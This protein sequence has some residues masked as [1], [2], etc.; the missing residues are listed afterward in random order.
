[1][2]FII[3]NKWM[4][5]GYGKSLRNYVKGFTIRELL[6]F[7]DLPVFEEATTY[8]LIIA[9]SKTSGGQNFKA[10][11]LQTLDF[12]MGIETY[13]SENQLEVSPLGLSEDGWTLTDSRTQALLIK[14]KSQGVPLSEYVDGKIFYGIK[15]GYNEAFVIDRETKERLIAEDPRSAEVIKP[16]L[17]GRDIKRYQ[18]PRSDKF[19]IL[20]PKGFTIKRNLPDGDP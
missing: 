17:A 6:D 18:Q 3:P 19:L 5:A 9:L 13:L 11:N 1:F 8:P 16:F 4:R 20:F 15:T 14:L 7:G 10:V 2:I 12:P